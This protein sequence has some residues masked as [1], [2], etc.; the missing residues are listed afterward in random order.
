MDNLPPGK[1][2]AGGILNVCKK[3]K[4]LKKLSP[5]LINQLKKRGFNIHVLKGKKT[6]ALNLYRDKEGNI[7]MH[8]GNGQGPGEPLGINIK[9]LE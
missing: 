6:G 2:P 4:D 3:A 9:D 8:P 5:Y 1:G 7:S